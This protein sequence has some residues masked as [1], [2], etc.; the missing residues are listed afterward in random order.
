MI[1]LEQFLKQSDPETLRRLEAIRK[2]KEIDTAWTVR[3]AEKHV[4]KISDSR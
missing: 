4:R 2:Q 3:D 1:L